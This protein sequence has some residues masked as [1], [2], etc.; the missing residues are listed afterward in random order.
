MRM[1]KPLIVVAVL[2]GLLLIIAL[3]AIAPTTPSAGLIQDKRYEAAETAAKCAGKIGKKLRR[4]LA[5]LDPEECEFYLVD[6]KRMGWTEVP[7]GTYNEMVVGQYY[8]GR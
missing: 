8:N 7:C 3:V 1:K 2:I 6:G 5:D 4:C